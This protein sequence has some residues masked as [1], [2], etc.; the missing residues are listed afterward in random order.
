MPYGLGRF[1]GLNVFS[2]NINEV[3]GAILDFFIQK[4]HE[5]KKTQNA[6]RLTKIKNAPKNRHLFAY[7]HL[8]LLPEY[9]YIVM[10]ITLFCI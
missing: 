6:F 8:V 10:T 4:F 9:Y 1:V 3:I 2:S 7:L 5:Q